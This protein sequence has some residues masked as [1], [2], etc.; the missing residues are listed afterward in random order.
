MSTM[1][2]TAD[3]LP[4]LFGNKSI[5]KTMRLFLLNAE[6]SFETSEVRTRTKTT[7]A[8]LRSDM[9]R[10][11]AI[12]FV[13]KKTIVKVRPAK[14]KKG[15]GMKK[16]VE[17]WQLNA[18]F[19]HLSA[20]KLMLLSDHMINKT[21]AVK[22]MRRAGRI[23]L[24]VLSGIFLRETDGNRVDV[25]VVGDKLNRT[26]LETALRGLES[27]VG[28]ELSYAIMDSDEFNYRIGMYD[29]FIRDILDYPHEKLVNTLGV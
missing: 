5:V 9:A 25:L 26:S 24:V 16:K 2:Q 19:P 29:K 27:E 13:K 4:K 14:T 22:R 20:L 7:P 18:G 3:I 28:K 8:A 15:K 1:A 21:E 17:T 23:K 11:R 12:G 6:S 10:L